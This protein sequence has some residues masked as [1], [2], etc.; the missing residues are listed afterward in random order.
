MA[1]KWSSVC[2]CTWN[3][4]CR[5][6]SGLQ[7][8]LARIQEFRKRLAIFKANKCP[9][10][11]CLCLSSTFARMIY[12][13]SCRFRL[14]PCQHENKFSEKGWSWAEFR[15]QNI[16]YCGC[17]PDIDIYV[18]Q[19]CV[20]ADAGLDSDRRPTQWHAITTSL[21]WSFKCFDLVA[22]FNLNQITFY[23]L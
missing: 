21:V 14:A 3:H 20:F 22:C 11:P 2:T 15:L 18:P 8:L 16:K 4:W 19:Y 17:R 9:E 23:G 5:R 13:G 10:K 7:L 12:F 1:L 6:K